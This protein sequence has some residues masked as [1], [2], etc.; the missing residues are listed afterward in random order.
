[1]QK[2]QR[3][4]KK[5]REKNCRSVRERNTITLAVLSGQN[6]GLLIKI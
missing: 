6:T 4:N 1:M 3:N 5:I 2:Q